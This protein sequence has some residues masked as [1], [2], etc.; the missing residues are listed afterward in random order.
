MG[1][2]RMIGCGGRHRRELLIDRGGARSKGTVNRGKKGLADPTRPVGPA[3]FRPGSGPSF[4]RDSSSYFALVA[5]H[6]CHFEVVIPAIM[7]G[8]FSY[9]VRTLRLSPRG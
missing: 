5:L 7:I 3:C 1:V 8:V 6:L 9:E 4:S 2:G